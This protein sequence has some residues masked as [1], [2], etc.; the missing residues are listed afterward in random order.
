MLCQC[1]M[2]QCKPRN[3]VEGDPPEPHCSWVELT[4]APN[5]VC[6][7]FFGQGD[8]IKNRNT[9][10]KTQN[11]DKCHSWRS[12][13]WTPVVQNSWLLPCFVSHPTSQRAVDPAAPC[14]DLC[15]FRSLLGP[16]RAAKH[17]CSRSC[18]QCDSGRSCVQ[19]KG[20]HKK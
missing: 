18:F 3:A 10:I 14:R 12:E 8:S 9:V 7:L 4:L 19:M 17:F 5:T 11:L 13:W 15:A 2:L 6:P 16:F 20:L 1:W